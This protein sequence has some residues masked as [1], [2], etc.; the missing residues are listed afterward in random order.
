MEHVGIVQ[1]IGDFPITGDGW[2]GMGNPNA[3]FYPFRV[4]IDGEADLQAGRYVS[5]TYSASSAENGVYLEN[6]F[7]LTEAGNNYV[8]IRD[9]N[10]RL[11]KRS[12]VVGKSLWGSYK[13]ILSGVSP[14]DYLA[15]PYGK[16]VR[17]GAPTVESDISALYES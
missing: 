1:S 5:I 15:F 9:E 17:D 11:E 16:H 8:Y 14:D 12:V 7:I 6:P 2:T 4:Y 10:G 13:Q 3:S